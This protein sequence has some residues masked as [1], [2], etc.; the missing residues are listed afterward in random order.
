MLSH[1]VLVRVILRSVRRLLVTAIVVPSAPILVTLMM[2][3]LRSSAKPVLTRETCHIIQEDGI[4]DSHCRENLKSFILTIFDWY[5]WFR[6]KKT[7]GC[8]DHV[9]KLSGLFG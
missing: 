9:N 1:L 8:V 4:I 2:E 7:N 5:S 3:A 6:Q